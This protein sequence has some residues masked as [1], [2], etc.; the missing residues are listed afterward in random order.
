MIKLFALAGLL[1][2]ANQSMTQAPGSSKPYMI[3][4]GN[5]NH[6]F[7][8]EAN[9]PFAAIADMKAED[10]FKKAIAAYGGEKA[11]AAL[12][13]IQ[14]NGSVSVMGQ[15]LDYM[16][17]NVFP[18]GFATTVSMAGSP[19]MKQLKKDTAY[20]MQM[21]GGA[22]MGGEIDDAAKEEIDTRAAF[23]SE[24]YMLANPSYT[25][26]L[27]GTEQVAGK[28]A[29]VITI[30]SPKGIESTL[31]YDVA[32]GLKVQEKRESASPMGGQMSITTSYAEYKTFDGI[33]VPT[34]L[35]I[36]LGQF[37]QDIIINEV[38]VNQGLKLS[39]L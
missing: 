30:L 4:E 24:R 22:D 32:S 5:E 28:D 21:P 10:I 1:I 34:K 13:D 14:M 15:S 16:Q 29:Y 6:L 39:D 37:S 36:D 17:K 35:T 31:Y 27:K 3:S 7:K 25:Y 23:F 11:I 8:Q 12:K 38:K 19:I 33:T 26:T 2:T 20:E 18:S 9:E